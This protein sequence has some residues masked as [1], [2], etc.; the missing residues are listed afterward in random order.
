MTF[1]HRYHRLVNQLQQVEIK[2]GAALS[3]LNQITGHDPK[4]KEESH[5]ILRWIIN[6]GKWI[7]SHGVGTAVIAGVLT[8]IAQSF[9]FKL[10]IVGPI[11]EHWIRTSAQ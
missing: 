8:Y 5:K 1:D 10:S 7:G 4:E 6:R 9:G 11:I 2:A 3:E